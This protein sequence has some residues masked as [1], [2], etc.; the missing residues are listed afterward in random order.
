MVFCSAASETS[1]KPLS[2]ERKLL[3]L[4][5]SMCTPGSIWVNHSRRAADTPKR[6]AYSRVIQLSPDAAI[7][8]PGNAQTG[9]LMIQ[10]LQGHAD[11][12][13]RS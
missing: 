2:M 11:E 4:I 13:L 6:A 12:V 5:L 9:L 3:T 1:R 8:D 10:L 7:N